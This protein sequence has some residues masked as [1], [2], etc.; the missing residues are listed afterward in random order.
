[1]DT[2]AP[3]PSAPNPRRT[4]ALLTGYLDNLRE[5]VLWKVDGLDESALREPYTPTGT[6]LLGLV[7]HLAAIEY[8]YFQMGFGR[9]YP[10]LPHLRADADRISDFYATAEESADEVIQ[11]YREAIAASR[12]TCEE[13]ELDAVARLPWRPEPMTLEHVLLHVAVE[14]ARHAGHAD[15][16]REQVDGMA[17]LNE[18]NPNLSGPGA[19]RDGDPFWDEH[20]THLR[21]LAKQAA[22]GG[23]GTG[24]KE[25]Q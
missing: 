4:K 20:L 19:P 18:G 1:M 14:T 13:L 9:P 12:Q 6:N 25:E 24:T 3:N 5:A 15:I 16:V 8:G 22:V 11:T 10:D 17:G 23:L 7:K 2:P 21:T